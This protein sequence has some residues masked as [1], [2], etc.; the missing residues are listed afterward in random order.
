MNIGVKIVPELKLYIIRKLL[1]RIH[2]G[3]G[4]E[5]ELKT[6]TEHVKEIDENSKKYLDLSG[7]TDTKIQK[8][9]EDIK[10]EVARSKSFNFKLSDNQ[11]TKIMR[12]VDTLGKTLSTVEAAE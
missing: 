12:N 4:L 2:Y 9:Y 7:I 5:G 10:N 8:L 11:I 1:P 6:I 3:S